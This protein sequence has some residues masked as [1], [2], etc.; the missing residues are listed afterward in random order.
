MKKSHLKGE[1]GVTVNLDKDSNTVT[2]RGGLTDADKQ[3]YC[4]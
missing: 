3:K 4:K 2:I 1:N